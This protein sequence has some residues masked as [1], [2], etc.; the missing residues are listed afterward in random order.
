MYIWWNGEGSLLRQSQGKEARESH[1]VSYSPQ[2]KRTSS[3]IMYTMLWFTSKGILHVY[4]YTHPQPKYMR[5]SSFILRF[6]PTLSG[7][8]LPHTAYFLSLPLSQPFSFLLFSCFVQTEAFWRYIFLQFLANQCVYVDFLM[9][10][11]SCARIF[12]VWESL[13]KTKLRKPVLLR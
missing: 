10:P 9:H 6:P 4:V 1:I 7:S 8:C 13:Y 11:W 12:G 5:V 3:F 2:A